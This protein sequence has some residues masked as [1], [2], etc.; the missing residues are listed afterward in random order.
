MNP[1]RISPERATEILKNAS[2]CGELPYTFNKY[3]LAGFK[4]HPLGITQE[5]NAYI[6]VI[7]SLMDPSKSFYDALKTIEKGLGF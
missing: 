6:S 2:W 5:E 3:G 7:W 4:P 1:P